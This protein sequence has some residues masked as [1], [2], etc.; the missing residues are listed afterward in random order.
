MSVHDRR[1]FLRIVVGAGVACAGCAG[2]DGSSAKT[3]GDVSGG[4]A[5]ALAVGGVQA[6]SG[7]PA[8]LGRDAKGL[9]AMTTTCTHQACDL[10]SSG[11]ISADRITCGCHGS[12]FDKTGEVLHGPASSP[13]QHFAVTVDANG[14]ITVHGGQ[15]VS[16]DTRTAVG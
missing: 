2:A 11:T 15:P 1:G 4:N 16:S 8:F 9:Y 14:A 3:F 7:A 13:L 10:A 12:Q 6:V 5:S